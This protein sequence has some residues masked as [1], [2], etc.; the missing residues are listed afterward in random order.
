VPS[1]VALDTLPNACFSFLSSTSAADDE[2]LT[3]L[4]QTSLFLVA[5][6]IVVKSML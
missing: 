3:R 6:T 2:A 4:L 1:Q 5:S